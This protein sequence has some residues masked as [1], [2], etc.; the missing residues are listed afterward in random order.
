[1]GSAFASSL[2]RTEPVV[3]RCG[4][5][6]AHALGSSHIGRYDQY[7]HTIPFTFFT[8]PEKCVFTCVLYGLKVCPYPLPLKDTVFE[9]VRTQF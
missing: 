2:L 5:A 6:S 8:R 7:V 4:S 3:W 1:M 9:G